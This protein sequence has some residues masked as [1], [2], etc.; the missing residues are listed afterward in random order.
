MIQ[1][2]QVSE[3]VARAM[4][5]GVRKICSSN[6]GLSITGIA[7][8]AGGSKEK[9]VGLVYIAVA[10]GQQT[11]VQKNQLNGDRKIIRLRATRRALN[12]LRL[13]L[14]SLTSS[15]REIINHKTGKN[16]KFKTVSEEPSL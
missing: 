9:P 5:L 12:I 13:Y 11:F 16:K 2:G 4:A 3:Q 6:I 14:I 1:V 7:G 10:D 15:N 8:P